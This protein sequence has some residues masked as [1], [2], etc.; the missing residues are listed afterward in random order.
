MSINFGFT[1]LTCFLHFSFQQYLEKILSLSLSTGTWRKMFPQCEA[2]LSHSH[3][4]CAQ[5]F[6]QIWENNTQI[7]LLYTLNYLCSLKPREECKD[8]P[9]EVSTSKPFERQGNSKNWIRFAHGWPREVRLRSGRWS[10]FG[11][12]PQ[13]S[14]GIEEFTTIAFVFCFKTFSFA[15]EGEIT[16][17]TECGT[18]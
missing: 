15:Q 11:V 10:S 4:P 9:Q 13:G 1:Y 18:T 16:S 8:V 14:P 3:P 17:T 5:V 2:G 7:Y 12:S 6:T